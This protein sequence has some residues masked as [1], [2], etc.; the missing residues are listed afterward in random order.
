MLLWCCLVVLDIIGLL[1]VI[2]K[3]K[4]LVKRIVNFNLL[5]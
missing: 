1:A 5:H 2:A 4:N 3:F